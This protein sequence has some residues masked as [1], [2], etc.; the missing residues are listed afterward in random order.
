M[1]EIQRSGNFD[2][3]RDS[4]KN[5]VA[6]NAPLIN[7]KKICFNST[8]ANSHPSNLIWSFDLKNPIQNVVGFDWFTF[9]N[10]D[11]PSLIQIRELPQLAVTS[12]GTPY[13][14][15]FNNS[16]TGTNWNFRTQHIVK[17]SPINVSNLTFSFFMPTNPGYSQTSDWSIEICFIINDTNF[18][19]N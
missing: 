12:A 3:V 7:Y 18:T 15:S 5:N 2:N 10:I 8:E 17:I 14:F 4:Y 11:N 19:L 16:S 6:V 13:A 9:N 1:S